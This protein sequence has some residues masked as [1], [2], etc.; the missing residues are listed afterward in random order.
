MITVSN[1]A[2]QCG[3]SRTTVLYYEKQKLLQPS[4][5]GANGYRYYSEADAECLRRILAYRSAGLPVADIRR[6]LE[7]EKDG[8]KITQAH[9]FRIEHEIQSLRRQQYA[10]VNLFR[11]QISAG[12]K[13]VT[14]EEWVQAMRDAGMSDGDMD[15][16]HR[17]FESMIPGE[18]E[19]FLKM[20]GCGPAERKRIRAN[21]GMVQK[22]A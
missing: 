11:A 19:A 8:D 4:T 18:H 21:S 10:M 7:T 3:I 22:D 9:F 15:E 2:R 20:I 17:L 6:L 13:K 5:R 12:S 1:L 16:W 14:K